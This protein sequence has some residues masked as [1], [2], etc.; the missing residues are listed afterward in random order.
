MVRKP[1][2]RFLNENHPDLI[3]SPVPVD[4][5]FNLLP[6][7]F[8]PL[9]DLPPLD[10]GEPPTAVGAAVIEWWA[11]EYK[12]DRSEVPT[13][14]VR[15]IEAVSATPRNAEA[16]RKA[17]WRRNHAGTF[18]VAELE[19]L[20]P[21][22]RGATVQPR[23]AASAQ[24]IM[25][26]T[27]QES[28]IYE[29]G[30]ELL[31]A[32]RS[33]RH[34]YDITA[35]QQ[36]VRR[37]HAY[38]S[39]PEMEF[40][41]SLALEGIREEIRGFAFDVRTDDGQR[42]HI[43]ETNDGW[44]RI[45]VAQATMGMLMGT[46][47]TNLSTLHWEDPDG[48]LTVRPFTPDAI[49]RVHAALQFSDAKFQVWPDG[50][51]ANAIERWLAQASPAAL[52]VIRMMTARMDIGIAVRP[53]RGNSV[54]DVVYADMA[55]FHVRGH[56][57]TLWGKADDE[58]FKARTV[59]NDLVRHQYVEPDERAVFFGEVALPWADDPDRRPF[60]N[61]VVATTAVMI[62]STIEDPACP[63]RYAQVR[64]TLKRLQIPNSPLQAAVSTAAL[65]GLV[66]GLDGD[67]E[68]GQFTAVVSR[69]FRKP[70]L[71]SIAQH[72]GNWT[73]MFDRDLGR[74]ADAARN[75]LAAQAGTESARELGANQRALAVLALVAHAS[76]PALRDYRE[77]VGTQPN[78]SPRTVR[79]PSSMTM[80]GRGGRGDVRTVD[81]DVVLFNA[82]RSPDGIDE[83]EAIV[84]ATTMGL[85]VV[86][87]S[88]STGEE[89]LEVWLRRRWDPGLSDP[90]SG[91]SLIDG[92]DDEQEHD[93][94][95]PTTE[96]RLSNVGEWG[97]AVTRM[98]DRL[99]A[100][101]AETAGMA[102]VP[103]NA[104]LAGV[105]EET[106]DPEDE[107]LPRMVDVAGVEPTNEKASDEALETLRQ[108]FR[109]GLRGF[110]NRGGRP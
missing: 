22:V 56:S 36:E 93:R 68:M 14:V 10:D 34:L 72:R 79:R 48:E 13:G 71:R 78:G 49:R 15:A 7:T 37:P 94:S 100:M 73:E 9:V 76:N 2:F 61:R 88:P 97:M 40:V 41:D 70:E 43:V 86:P 103:A 20:V 84:A 52:A 21:V 60:R 24:R 54:H 50:R 28:L 4:R 106:Y 105:P 81:A 69:S 27:Y 89:M 59:I 38:V 85:P 32:A 17:R 62:A 42:G 75:E 80:T 5:V 99:E 96:H 87:R 8:D 67:G 98:V 64:A 45:N 53:Y 108:F 6:P 55:R 1:K 74:I 29:V 39:G 63:A 90:G 104:A 35:A 51:T 3:A 44:T 107:S 58:A 109:R 91:S 57:P 102:E 66:A 18:A 12:C 92:H 19:V 11:D 110:A 65:A 82:A 47:A 25:R 46:G 26:E 23:M 33:A 16:I 95:A 83:L 31:I 30:N 101:A 77:V